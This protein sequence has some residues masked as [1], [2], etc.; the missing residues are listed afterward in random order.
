MFKLYVFNERGLK[1]QYAEKI[2]V[3]VDCNVSMKLIEST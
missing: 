2:K 3:A 1:S